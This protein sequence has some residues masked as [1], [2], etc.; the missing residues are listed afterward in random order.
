MT[1]Y[2][3][4]MRTRL[5]QYDEPQKVQAAGVYPFFRT[6]ESE[7]DTE[8]L[9]NGRKVLMFGSN[10]YLGL[11][12]HPKVK[13]AA[14]AAVRKYGTGC[15]GSRYLNG[16]LD[17]HV[18][19]ENKLA[20]FVGKDGALV[21][22]T[23]FQANLGAIPT[24]TSRNDYILLD[25]LDHASIIEGARLSFAKTLKFRHN[26]MAS[27]EKV[28][29]R[30]EPDVLKLIVVDGIFSME[31]D[32]ACLPEIVHLAKKYNANIMVDDAHSF[33]VLGEQGRGV[34]SHFGLTDDVDIIMGTFSKSL[35][36]IGGFLAADK[37]TI[38][39]IKHTSRSLIF[40]AS[41]TP[42]ATASALAALEIIK[43][44]PQHMMQLWKNTNYCLKVFRSLGFDIAHSC[45]PIIPIMIRDNKKTFMM[46]KLLLEDGV[47]VNPV[48]HPAVP[49]NSTLIR[50]SL[51]ATH[52]QQ[53][54]EFAIDKIEKAAR[55]LGII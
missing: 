48:P 45:T 5:A 43:T 32:I 34:S 39:C 1:T 38:N 35:A 52:T 10:S 44:E 51:M 37:D 21:Y 27:L 23:G 7:Q 22:S 29:Q 31:G 17:I 8:V 33:G 24:V 2:K 25:D 3:N 26:D 36:S 11:T 18:E 14:V 16:T 6:I 54:I 41:A 12:S 30:C 46:T 19:L 40:S 42:A 20:E 50:F 49:N 47:F 13:E 15:A 4:I 9:I 55:Q 53:Q 28:L